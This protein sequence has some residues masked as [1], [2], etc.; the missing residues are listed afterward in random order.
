MTPA[1]SAVMKPSSAE[2]ASTNSCR[3]SSWERQIQGGDEMIN[4]SSHY[5]A[6]IININLPPSGNNSY[7]QTR[8][9]ALQ[10]INIFGSSLPLSHHL[11]TRLRQ[12]QVT[13]QHS[14]L[15]R[16]RDGLWN[17]VSNRPHQN[18]KKLRCHQFCSRLL[19][20]YLFFILLLNATLSFLFL[21]PDCPFI[22]FLVADACF[23][24]AAPYNWLYL[25]W[26]HGFVP[27]VRLN[28]LDYHRYW[29]LHLCR[30]RYNSYSF[31]ICQCIKIFT[32]C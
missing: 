29:L 21:S 26:T 24:M 5:T 1:S 20:S 10:R 32:R 7:R 2:P 31:H 19:Q 30:W 25:Y 14:W 28:S 4:Q 16:I 17:L 11:Y 12:H 18:I 15:F 13:L 23:Y 6:N 22:A 3:A 9:L 27:T 8:M